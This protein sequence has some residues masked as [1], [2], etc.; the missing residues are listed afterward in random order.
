MPA[1]LTVEL[2]SRL[3]PHASSDLIAGIA[4]HGDASLAKWQIDTPGRIVDFM[5]QISEETGGGVRLE[6]NLNY[7][8]ERAAEVWP[9]R[10]PTVAAAEPYAHNPKALA[11]LVYGGRYG[12]RPGSND[13]YD[14]RG[15][16]PM[17]LT[18]RGV[19]EA[20]GKLTGL[21]LVNHPELA[22][23][24]A[25]VI[26]VSAAYW[27]MAGVNS[28]ADSGDFV[29][30]TKKIN[31]G[32]T[33]YE[34]RQQWREIWRQAVGGS[35]PK[36]APAAA[37]LDEITCRW[38][39]TGLNALGIPLEPLL[40]DGKFGP[41]T[42]AEV[43]AFQQREGLEIDGLVGKKTIDALQKALTALQAPAA[44]G[45]A[46]PPAA[47]AGSTEGDSDMSDA[48]SKALATVPTASDSPTVDL[49]SWGKQFLEKI[50]P[51]VVKAIDEGV[52]VVEHTV[53]G[54]FIIGMVIGPQLVD[55]WAN[56]AVD[57]VEG[58]IESGLKIELPTTGV[59]GFITNL[60]YSMF[61]SNDGTVLE[62][63][64]KELETDV[65]PLITGKVQ[66]LVDAGRAVI[67]SI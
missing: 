41:K 46:E 64:E 9:S 37:G 66:S 67:K 23:D 59:A 58:M 48:A 38:V 32:L 52:Q 26:E 56:H 30:E 29:G 10:F 13:G 5:A 3:W 53:P 42:R 45:N 49:G 1:T 51:A 20:V 28:F 24:P 40:V 43:K 63:M 8:A 33:N 21:D 15:R 17:Q 6:E 35:A 12:N 39:Q 27:H 2:L 62:F 25:N 16:S 19:Y 47:P 31:G 11:N 14:F 7:T 57:V 36:P 65:V 61:R 55:Q 4:A 44:G 60:A 54:G 34:A 18:F 22:L 50:R